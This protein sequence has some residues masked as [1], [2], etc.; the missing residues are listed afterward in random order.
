M[1]DKTNISWCDRTHNHW[2]GCT[3]KSAGCKFCYA[4]HSTPSRVLRANGQEAWGPQGVRHL[5]SEA[6]RK[7][8]YKWNKEQ[9]GECPGCH[10]RGNIQKTFVR[11]DQPLVCPQCATYAVNPTR[12][13]V[14]CSSLSDVF[15]G[16]AETLDWL[17]DLG[18]PIEKCRNLDWLLLTKRPENVVQLI[19]ECMGGRI[20]DL[21]LADNPHVWI[22]FTGENQEEFDK[23]WAI[24]KH[25]PASIIFCSHEPLL[26]GI[27]LPDDYLSRGQKVWSLVGGESGK[28]ARPMHPDWARSLRDQCEAAGIPF[29][30]KQQGDAQ[31][32]PTKHHGGDLLD[33]R[34][35]KE[36]PKHE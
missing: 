27:V 9:W 18:Q 20:A 23:R 17:W 26:G 3:Q 28:Q 36:F 33:G 2:I 16:R 7:K 19:E 31:G 12:Q 34:T 4:E 10:W 6:N 30:F 32:D 13:R 8:P 22:G 15:E 25:I 24:A 35:Y 21:W 5:T 29:L 14:F 11:D 1:G